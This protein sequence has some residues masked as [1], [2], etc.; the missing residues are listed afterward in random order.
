MKR[1]EL[2][3][4]KLNEEAG[5]LEVW[6]S[7]S[8]HRHFDGYA[9]YYQTDEKGRKLCHLYIGEYYRQNLPIQWSVLIRAV[10]L[11]LFSGGLFACIFG[12]C[13]PVESNCTWYV[14][15]SQ[16]AALPCAFYGFGA[17]ICYVCMPVKMK[18]GRYR[19]AVKGLERGSFLTGCCCIF[20]SAATMI[21]IGSHL[22]TCEAETYKSA[23]LFLAAGIQMLLIRMIESRVPYETVKNNVVLPEESVIL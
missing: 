4:K 3:N 16:A 9:E 10:Y 11:G 5:K 6:H 20:S 2:I 8:Y 22:K 17:L 18:R 7:T 19:F 14:N 12:A 23:Y 13:I 15:L 21:F 1:G